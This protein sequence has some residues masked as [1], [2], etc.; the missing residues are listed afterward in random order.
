LVF[1]AGGAVGNALFFVAS[2]LKSDEIRTVF[3]APETE[4]RAKKGG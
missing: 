1:P 4:R 3:F 2:K